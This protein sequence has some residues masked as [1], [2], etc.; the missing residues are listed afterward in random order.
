[1]EAASE[2]IAVDLD[3]P[4]V[5]FR[6]LVA[7]GEQ[8]LEHH[9]DLDAVRRCQRVELERMLAD[10]Q[11]LVMGRAGNR[12]VDGGEAAAALLVPGPDFWGLVAVVGR[13][14]VGHLWG[15]RRAAMPG[16]A[17][18]WLFGRGEGLPRQ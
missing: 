5:V 16:P 12:P 9:G 8:L 14:R 18:Y 10:R 7:G 6:A 15:S 1:D 17:S 11:L 2:L 4:G 13:R 3:Q